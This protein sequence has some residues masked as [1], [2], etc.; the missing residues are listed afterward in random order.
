VSPAT[1]HEL[2]LV[3]DEVTAAVHAQVLRATYRVATTV[4]PDVATQ[5]VA[6]GTPA[7]VVLDLDTVG[8]GKAICRAAKAA[9]LPPTT[10]VIASHADAVPEVLAAGCDAVLLKPFAPN[11]LYSRVGRLLRDRA[12]RLRAR[13]RTS[14]GSNGSEPLATTHR[15][16][17]ETSCP[18]CS[19]PG[20]VSFEFS[21]HRRA[22]YACLGCKG[23][24]VGKRQE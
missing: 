13:P 19:R 23:V 9:A 12:N 7:L 21:S 10:L 2:L 15:V 24:W 6:K 18:T 20:A 22:W 4:N 11:L 5:Y 1:T 16:W 14:D 17:P 8:D 3:E